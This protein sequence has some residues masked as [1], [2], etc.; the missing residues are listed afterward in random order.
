MKTIEFNSRIVGKTIEIPPGKQ[1]L[2]EGRKDV[3]VIILYEGQEEHDE[4]AFK[5]L[6]AEQF[7]AGYDEEDA[8]YDYE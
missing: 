4:Q 2:L 7:L 8:I 5:K 3:K 6:V 1:I